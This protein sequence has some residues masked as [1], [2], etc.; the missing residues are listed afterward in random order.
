MAGNTWLATGQ[1][2]MSG[3]IKYMPTTLEEV[4]DESTIDDDEPAEE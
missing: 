3:W 2:S 4:G 1:Y